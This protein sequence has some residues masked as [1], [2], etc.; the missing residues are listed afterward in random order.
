[1]Q[2]KLDFSGLERLTPRA[3]SWEKICQRLDAEASG[4]KAK[5]KRNNIIPFKILSAIPLAASIALVSVSVLMTAFTNTS[6]S[7]SINSVAPAEVSSW[8]KSLGTDSNDDYDT[9][10]EN[11]A[12]SY[13]YKEAK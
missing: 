3:D 11:I 8:Y 7:I 5:A 1:M 4:S 2:N 10:D 12:L 13:F 6:E 9:L